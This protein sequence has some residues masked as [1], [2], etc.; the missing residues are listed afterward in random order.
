[1]DE[2][3]ET[4]HLYVVREEIPKPSLFPVLLSGL[5]LSLLLIYCILVPY[6]QP[7]LRAVIRVP[8]VFLPIQ[9]FG[10]SVGIVPTGRKTYVATSAH[11]V[12]AL[13]NGSIITQQIPQ[14]MIL[15]STQGVEVVVEDTVVVPAGNAPN[16]GI[17]WVTTH[18]LV[19]GKRGNIPAY[20]VNTVIN[21]SIYIRNL[22]RFTGGRDAYSVKIV[23][24]QDRQTALEKAR[25]ILSTSYD[26]PITQFLAYPCKEHVNNDNKHVKLYVNW[27]CQFYTY[28]V[29][30][31][32][33]VVKVKLL[34]KTAIIDGF[35]IVRSR[36][37]TGK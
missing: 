19:S 26:P 20:G 7:E 5:T 35:I 30:P 24:P 9:N 21:S 17:A 29:S 12:L 1:M 37:F 2:K 36:P 14:G 13:Y 25:N 33:H 22:Q 18:A 16:F 8:A 15:T 31:I 4:I 28:S 11:G 6:R 3:P 10:I 23:T 34:G 27:A 32:V